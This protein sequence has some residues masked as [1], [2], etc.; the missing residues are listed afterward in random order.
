[1]ATSG[2]GMNNPDSIT[3]KGASDL[4]RFVWANETY[5]ESLLIDVLMNI[6]YLTDPVDPG[7][8]RNSFSL[9]SGKIFH[10]I[11]PAGREAY[12]RKVILQLTKSL[13][14]AAR[15]G[16]A[17]VLLGNEEDIKVKQFSAFANDWA[18]AVITQS[19]GIDY[20]ENAPTKIYEEA[21]PL[22]AQWLGEYMGWNA[23]MALVER[24][25]NN[26]TVAPI[27]LTTNWNQNWY[28]ASAT[29]QPAY[30][31]TPATYKNNI[32]TV[33]DAVTQS[34]A[35]LDIGMILDIEEE[36]RNR[37]IKPIKFEGHDLYFFYV[38]PEEYK[39]LR[40]PAI[41]ASVGNY[42]VEA[43]AL[44]SGELDK[45]VPGDK[46]V[47]G[48]VVVCRDNRNAGI[49]SD[50]P[51]STTLNAYYLKQGRNDERTTIPD[52]KQWNAN[53]LL[54]ESALVKFQ[55]EK[56]HYEK[57]DDEYDKFGG[58]GYI[59]ACSYQI[60]AFDL[61]TP[62]DSSAQQEGSMIVVT[63]RT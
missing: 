6:P 55:P 42:W 48:G 53:I 25:S 37:Y 12:A 36:A 14:G 33:M 58:V 11:T 39:R 61:D 45:I 29:T 27:S 19:Y 15:E 30:S 47:V 18:H 24:I 8:D 54:G 50:T 13:N 22:L 20:R 3:A 51:A 59:G 41:T 34:A 60:P 9:K 44:G 7:N 49:G 46:F 57:Q 21:K 23:R 56:P 38:A 63:T 62:T 28:V 40:D 5:K 32:L 2:V 26:L 10:D 35:H 4:L 17:Q 43:A 52:A 31:A 1:M 16:N